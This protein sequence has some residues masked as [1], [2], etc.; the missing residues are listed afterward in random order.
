MWRRP[1]PDDRLFLPG[2]PIVTA[3]LERFLTGARSEPAFLISK[4][5]DPAVVSATV[6]QALFLTDSLPAKRRHYVP[7]GVLAEIR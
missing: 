6:S 3:F 4:P 5:F 7:D 2:S 1:H